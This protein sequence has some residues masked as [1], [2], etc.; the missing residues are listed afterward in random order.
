MLGQAEQGVPP[1]P[2]LLEVLEGVHGEPL[3][4]ALKSML[5]LSTAEGVRGYCLEVGLNDTQRRVVQEVLA[6]WHATRVAA[7]ARQASCVRLV[8][9]QGH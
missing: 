3:S 6:A 9:V 8:Q 2:A 7:I 1:P 4:H 5:T